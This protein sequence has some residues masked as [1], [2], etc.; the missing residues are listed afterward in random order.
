M[1]LSN[2]L[3]SGAWGWG[4]GGLYRLCC[5]LSVG[6]LRAGSAVRASCC[7]VVCLWGCYCRL[8]SFRLWGCLS[9]PPAHQPQPSVVYQASVCGAVYKPPQP[10]PQGVCGAMSFITQHACVVGSRRRRSWVC[11]TW[12]ITFVNR[13]LHL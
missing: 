6:L 5:G 12:N 1:G 7:V 13:I 11:F 8:S 3:R 4:W 9:T 10:Q 2:G